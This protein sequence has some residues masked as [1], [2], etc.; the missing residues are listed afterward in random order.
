MAEQGVQA[1]F[2]AAS[3]LVG[4]P[5]KDQVAYWASSEVASSAA[6]ATVVRTSVEPERL[7]LVG[8]QEAASLPGH[9]EASL[10]PFHRQE[11]FPQLGACRWEAG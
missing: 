11:A 8:C 4:F 7:V 1:G 6:V 9:R 2:K 10:R 5:S 3:S